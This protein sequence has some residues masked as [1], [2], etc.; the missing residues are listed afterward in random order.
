MIRDDF[1]GFHD[2]ETLT[3]PLGAGTPAHYGAGRIP[4]RE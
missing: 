1:S 2:V 4:G 3:F